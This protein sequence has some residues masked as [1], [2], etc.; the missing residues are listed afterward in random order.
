MI[1]VK[2][3]IFR[4]IRSG[5]WKRST[6]SGISIPCEMGPHGDRI[7]QFWFQQFVGEDAEPQI[8]AISEDQNKVGFVSLCSLAEKVILIVKY[9]M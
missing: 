5:F 6:I 4:K 2:G 9:Q 7:P 1:C 8:V 3:Y